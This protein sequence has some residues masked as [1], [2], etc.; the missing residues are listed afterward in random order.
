MKIKYLLFIFSFLINQSYSYFVFPLKVIDKFDKIENLLLFNS[1]YTT[2][3]IGTPIQKVN[4]FFSTTHNTLFLTD[5]GC[6]NNSLY[7]LFSSSTFLPL[8]NLDT[9]EEIKR[10]IF[11]ESLYFYDDLNLSNTQEMDEYPLFILS[12]YSEELTED[13]LCGDIGIAIMQYEKY[14]DEEPDEFDY[15]MKYMGTL[16]NYFSFI[17]INGNDYL[18]SSIFLNEDFEFKDLFKDVKNISWTY[19]ITRNNLLHWEIYMNDIFYN[20]VHIKDKIIIELSLLFELIVGVNNYK[21]NIQKDFFDSY[22]KKNICL[23]KEINGYSVFECDENKFEMKDIK[24]FPSL[25][26]YNY[27]INHIFIMNGEELFYKLNNKYYFKIVFPI[28]DFQPNR[29]IFGKIFF[30]KYPAIFSPSNRRIGFYINPNG[31]IIDEEKEEPEERKEPEEEKKPEKSG[32]KSKV[33]IYV[34]IIVVALIFTGIGI[35]IGRN[36]LFKKKRKAN[37][38]VDDNYRYEPET[39]DTNIN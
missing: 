17:N 18:I 19:P 11:M 5:T 33:Y 9:D 21:K 1:T 14:G 8:G 35:F 15:Y 32:S 36:Y 31:D 29:W 12:N 10:I 13:G 16:N 6:R 37:E 26:I 25:Y 4:F 28:K 7:D 23:I 20:K 39:P 3:E 24:S 22:I 2:L 34:I 27:D 30:R 38:L